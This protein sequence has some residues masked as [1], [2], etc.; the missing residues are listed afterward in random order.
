MDEKV[1]H[2]IMKEYIKSYE[3]IKHLTDK[4]VLCEDDAPALFKKLLEDIIVTF[5]SEVEE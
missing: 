1:W 2:T 4:G 3:A 5:E